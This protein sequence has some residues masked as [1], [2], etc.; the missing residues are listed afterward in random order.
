MKFEPELNS[1]E[2][3]NDVPNKDIVESREKM[4]NGIE[5]NKELEGI[6]NRAGQYIQKM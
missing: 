1:K 4:G 2:H 6:N 3:P 5:D